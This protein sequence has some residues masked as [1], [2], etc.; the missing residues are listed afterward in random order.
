M[1][2]ATKICVCACNS[3]L[4]VCWT[5]EIVLRQKKVDALDKK[6][7]HVS[8]NVHK[9]YVSMWRK[10]CGVALGKPKKW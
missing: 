10:L 3:I 1:Q 5:R 6:L 2:T 8:K 9:N 7:Y 4:V